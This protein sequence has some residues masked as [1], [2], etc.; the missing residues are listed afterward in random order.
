MAGTIVPLWSL[1]GPCFGKAR[2]E[3]A[4]NFFAA[5][6]STSD[7]EEL[8]A[9]TLIVAGTDCIFFAQVSRQ[10]NLNNTREIERSGN[11]ELC[12]I[13]SVCRQHS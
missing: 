12:L 10:P 6:A 11:F 2:L 5:E 7:A 4:A 3:G 1:S 9:V 8:A 13:N